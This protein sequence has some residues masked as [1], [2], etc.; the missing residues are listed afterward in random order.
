MTRGQS[1]NFTDEEDEEIVSYLRSEMG[2]TKIAKLMNRSAIGIYNRIK[3]YKLNDF[4]KQVD[5]EIIPEKEH[6]PVSAPAPEEKPQ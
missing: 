6:D 2:V 4:A 3:K 5:N 1:K